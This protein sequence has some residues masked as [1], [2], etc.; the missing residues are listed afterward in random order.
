MSDKDLISSMYDREENF[1]YSQHVRLYTTTWNVCAMDPSKCN[2][3]NWI[4]DTDLTDVELVVI[5]LQE[6]VDLDNH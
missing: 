2:V 6:M 1:V 5:H 3:A 4:T